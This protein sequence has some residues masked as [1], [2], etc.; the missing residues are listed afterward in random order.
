MKVANYKLAYKK[1]AQKRRGFWAGGK[2]L[3]ILK[4]SLDV[5]FM[6]FYFL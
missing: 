5:T 2:V 3:G 6:S 1:T 4:S